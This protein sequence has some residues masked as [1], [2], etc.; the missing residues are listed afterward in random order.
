VR[1]GDTCPHCGSDEVAA[2]DL[3]GGKNRACGECG[4][5]WTVVEPS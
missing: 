1:T 2:V 3:P 4:E 5:T